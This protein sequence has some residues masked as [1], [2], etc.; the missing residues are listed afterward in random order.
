MGID[1]DAILMLGK[2][3]GDAEEATE[4]IKEHSTLSKNTLQKIESEGLED[5]CYNHNVLCGYTLNC[6]SGEG[7]IL[8]FN[9]LGYIVE[10]LKQ[11]LDK[12]Q[13]KWLKLFPNVEPEIICE[14]RIY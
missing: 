4:F 9:D 7:F 2:Q 3:F 6:Y 11:D 14:V 13:E 8:G 12:C 1:Y 5:W 10:G